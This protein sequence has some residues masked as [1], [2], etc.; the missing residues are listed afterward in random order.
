[1]KQSMR[2]IRDLDLALAEHGCDAR[3]ETSL[4]MDELARDL[5]AHPG[6]YFRDG[7]GVWDAFSLEVEGAGEL[8]IAAPADDDEAGCSIWYANGRNMDH[9]VVASLIYGL[10]GDDPMFLEPETGA[11]VM[12]DRMLATQFAAKADLGRFA[13]AAV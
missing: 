3:L 6:P 5:G 11:P 8:I 13:A 9:R 4:T 7:L 10:A 12:P 1:M 2:K